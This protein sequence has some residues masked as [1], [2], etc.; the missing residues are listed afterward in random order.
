M[1]LVIPDMDINKLFRGFW[2]FMM[3]NR[4]Y[5][6][7]KSLSVSKKEQRLK[8]IS[9]QLLVYENNNKLIKPAI[10]QQGDI[11]VDHYEYL[12]RLVISDM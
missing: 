9:K 1:M 5:K 11:T 3:Y 8:T 12:I 2:G 10:A 4:R 7:S 6:R